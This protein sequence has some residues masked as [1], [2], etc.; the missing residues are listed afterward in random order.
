MFL[1][2]VN[3]HIIINFNTTCNNQKLILGS[4]RPRLLE[5][6][7]AKETQLELWKNMFTNIFTSGL[8]NM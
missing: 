4:L 8:K 7:V 5:C 3:I 2:I 6:I 1:H